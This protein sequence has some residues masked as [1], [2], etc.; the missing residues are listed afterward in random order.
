MCLNILVKRTAC[1]APKHIDNGNWRFMEG[2]RRADYHFGTKIV[3]SC[4]EGYLTISGEQKTL[5]ECLEP[6]EWSDFAPTCLPIG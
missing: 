6:G 3:Y 5:L 4:D 2:V 1:D